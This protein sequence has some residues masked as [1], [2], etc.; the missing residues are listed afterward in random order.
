MQAPTGN[1]ALDQESCEEA[2]SVMYHHYLAGDRAATIPAQ[3]AENEIQALRQWQDANWGGQADLSME[4]IGELNHGFYGHSF[5][6]MPA[7]QDA[8]VAEIRGG[9]PVLVPSMTGTLRQQNPY[10]NPTHTLYHVVLLRG[11]DLG[12]GKVIANDEGVSQGR[13]WHYTWGI[14]FQGMDDA[15]AHVAQG[16]VMVVIS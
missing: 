6:V 16:H 8:I 13:D 14:I 11:F 12:A 15:N 9:H 1:W 3:Q 4:K 5:Q 2:A 7:T 10:F